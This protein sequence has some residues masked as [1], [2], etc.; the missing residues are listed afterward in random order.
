MKPNQT[1]TTDEAVS[2]KINQ[3]KK[4]AD[5]KTVVTNVDNANAADAKTGAINTDNANAAEANKKAN[6]AEITLSKYTGREWL[7]S[8]LL[9]FFI[10]LAI[11]VP[12]VSGATIAIIMGLYAKLVYALGNIFKD[13]KRCA[14]FLLPIVLG[15]LVGLMLGFF[16]VQRLIEIVPFILVCAFGGLMLGSF[17]AV[18]N[19]IK[20]EKWTKSG[21]VLFVVGLII[22][23]LV[24]VASIFLKGEVG[25]LNTAWYMFIAYFVIGMIV[26]L[27]QIV[28]GLSATALL[29]AM[30]LFGSLMASLHISSL[31]A[32]PIIIG[33]FAALGVG[34]L[35]GL[36]LFSKGISKLLE[37]KKK[38]MFRLI[39]GLSFGSII[40]MFISTEIIDVYTLWSRGA[41]N[42]LRDLLIGLPAFALCLTFA[43]WLTKHELK[44]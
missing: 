31:K 27:T 38:P 19:E 11:I 37:T 17:P 24:S 42:P 21:A 40:S 30:G 32:S 29:M 2:D 1:N 18:T 9:G 16:A 33:V 39:S 7:I 8:A 15:A 23:L 26:S 28:P 3:Q 22:P 10:G 44:K 41:G 13:F 35:V 20:G 43:L 12:G 36:V 6:A 4:A 34:F 5:A 14:G 25:T